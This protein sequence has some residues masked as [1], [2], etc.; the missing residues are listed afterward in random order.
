MILITILALLI[1]ISYDENA[2]GHPYAN[3]SN[4]EDHLYHYKGLPTVQHPFLP[5]IL[6]TEHHD[7]YVDHKEMYKNKLV[8]NPITP[9]VSDQRSLPGGGL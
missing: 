5:T 1:T 6:L 7:K 2:E 4:P 9:R 3:Y 8:I